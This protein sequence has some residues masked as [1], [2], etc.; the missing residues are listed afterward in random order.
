MTTR[1][2]RLLPRL[3]ASLETLTND[4]EIAEVVRQIRRIRGPGA[5]A[6]A[7]PTTDRLQLTD[8]RWE[9]ANGLRK[10]GMAMRFMQPVDEASW[11]RMAETGAALSMGAQWIPGPDARLMLAGVCALIESLRSELEQGRSA[12]MREQMKQQQS[13]AAQANRVDVGALHDAMM[14]VADRIRR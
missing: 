10:L 5:F 8:D 11:R 12:V 9:V 14:N 1:D 7:P 3:L 13:N 4:A 6:G 2:E